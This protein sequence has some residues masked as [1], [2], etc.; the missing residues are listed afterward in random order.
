MDKNIKKGKKK[1]CKNVTEILGFSLLYLDSVQEMHSNKHKQALHY[2]EI[3]LEISALHF[4]NILS[5]F[6]FSIT[7]SELSFPWSRKVTRHS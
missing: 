5:N 2:L 6:N 4:E 1:P 3:V 7:T